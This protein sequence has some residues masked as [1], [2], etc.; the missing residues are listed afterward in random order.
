M[1]A[2]RRTLLLTPLLPA[3]VVALGLAITYA[4]DPTSCDIIDASDSCSGANSA[5]AV[6]FFIGVPLVVLAIVCSALG[7]AFLAM[8]SWWAKRR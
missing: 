7:L 5:Y 8:Q 6:I 2:Y 1:H 4:L 3:G